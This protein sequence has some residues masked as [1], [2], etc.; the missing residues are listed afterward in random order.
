MENEQN[1]AEMNRLMGEDI[2]YGQTVQLRHVSGE[3]ICVKKTMAKFESQCLKVRR[4]CSFVT[5]TSLSEPCPG[6]NS[7]APFGMISD[8]CRI[9]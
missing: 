9:L 2:V 1:E 3:F 4:L 5:S 6:E 8:S 7:C